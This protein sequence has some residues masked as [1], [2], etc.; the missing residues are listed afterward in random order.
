MNRIASTTAR[1]VNNVNT[2][3]MCSDIGSGS[4]K[5][6]GS[7]GSL[8]DAG[9]AFGKLEAAREGEYFYKLNKKQL[10]EM[11]AHLKETAE[12][13]RIQAEK[14]L[15]QLKEIEKAEKAAKGKK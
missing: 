9:G 7:G 8:R 4:G 11:K 5:G 13:H 2:I 1:A 3:R 14:H 6:G 15:T 12:N 10:E